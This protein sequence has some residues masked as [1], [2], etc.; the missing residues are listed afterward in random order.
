M[1]LLNQ[2]WIQPLL[3]AGIF[4]L[5][6]QVFATIDD[7]LSPAAIAS[8]ADKVRSLD[9]GGHPD[10]L[11]VHDAYQSVFSPRHLS[12]RCAAAVLVVS[13]ICYLL[14]VLSIPGM[15]EVLLIQ[16]AFYLTE[17]MPL[18]LLVN[19][20]ADY[21][22]LAVTRL[23]VERIGVASGPRTL[24]LFAL[25][26]GAKVVLVWMIAYLSLS[27]LGVIEGFR[28][29]SPGVFIQDI[30]DT[31]PATFVSIFTPLFLSSLWI[32]IYAGCLYFL[33]RLASG[34]RRLLDFENHPVRG[35]G[36]VTAAASSVLGFLVLAATAAVS[37]A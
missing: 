32:W 31:E 9:P 36:L 12:P 21:V 16:P 6:Y 18:S 13:A 26:T 11:S 33:P 35:L 17:V 30:L 15:R 37:G 5:V 8:L 19:F 1:Q 24:A 4:P 22:A 29:G 3:A 23:L 25:D 27:L 10:G 7:N 34:L 28:M 20:V 2:I 14:T